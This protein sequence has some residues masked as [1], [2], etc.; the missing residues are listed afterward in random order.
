MELALIVEDILS[1][2]KLVNRTFYSR[3]TV[4]IASAGTCRKTGKCSAKLEDFL[5]LASTFMET[6]GLLQRGTYCL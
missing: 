6:A 1:D 4:N 5:E 3:V 2:S